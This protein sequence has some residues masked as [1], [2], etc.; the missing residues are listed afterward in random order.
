MNYIADFYC[1][2]LDLVIEIDGNSHFSAEAQK[3]DAERDR[4]MQAIGLR[5]LRVNDGDVR[6]DPERIA[7]WIVE[8]VTE[9]EG[10]GME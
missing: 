4:Q 8:Q 10:M 3:R 9:G 5:V 6:K 2:Q 7:N 1:K